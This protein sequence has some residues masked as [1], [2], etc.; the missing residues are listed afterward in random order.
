MNDL[1]LFNSGAGVDRLVSRH[2]EDGHPQW[3][4]GEALV[5]S[6]NAFGD[7]KHR[8]CWQPTYKNR[9]SDAR[10]KVNGQD[11]RGRFPV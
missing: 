11:L 4:V 1:V 5:Y 8:V 10:I 2:L 9:E 3:A 7:K 6:S